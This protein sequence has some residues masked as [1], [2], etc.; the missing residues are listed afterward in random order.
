MIQTVI[1]P[2]SFD[3]ANIARLGYNANCRAIATGVRTNFTTI[4]SG[5]VEANRT[6]MHLA[7]KIQNC[8]SQAGC[9]LSIHLKQIVCN[10]LC[11]LWPNARQTPQLVKEALQSMSVAGIFQGL[12]QPWNIESTSSSRDLLARRR[13]S[14]FNHIVNC[15]ENHVLQ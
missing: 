5:I 11:R 15:G 6:K 1:G 2:R 7:L 8:T 14:R 12:H 9:F 4:F 13:L 10:S 3:S